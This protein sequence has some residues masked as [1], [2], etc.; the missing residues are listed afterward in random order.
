MKSTNVLGFRRGVGRRGRIS[1]GIR[2][3]RRRLSRISGGRIGGLLVGAL[4]EIRI[5]M[6]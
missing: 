2:S 4:R 1:I 6:V 5:N 3:R